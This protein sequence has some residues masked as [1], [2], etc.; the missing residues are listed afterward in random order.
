MINPLPIKYDGKTTWFIYFFFFGQ[1]SQVKPSEWKSDQ[2]VFISQNLFDPQTTCLVPRYNPIRRIWLPKCRW[3]W[4]QVKVKCPKIGQNLKNR[5]YL[6][7][8]S[9]YRLYTWYQ[10]T[11]QYCPFNNPSDDDLDLRS[12]FKVKFS[13]KV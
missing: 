6:G 10:G 4:S 7:C 2:P 11:T 9:T 1:M 13:K 8:Y 5:P 3:S 12:R